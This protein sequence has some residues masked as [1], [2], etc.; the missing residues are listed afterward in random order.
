MENNKFVNG[1]FIYNPHPKAPEW[2]KADIVIDCD[3]FV[4][5]MRANYKTVE[6]NG[7]QSNQVKLQVK[8]SKDGKLYV[9]VNDYQPQ[10]QGQYQY[11]GTASPTMPSNAPVSHNPTVSQLTQN[12]APQANQEPIYVPPA[13]Y[14][15]VDNIPLDSIPF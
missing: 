6:I 7:R 3:K 15:E 2:V 13:G 4:E 8:V 12:N 10:N 14:Q 9:Q 11:N 1:L 5:W